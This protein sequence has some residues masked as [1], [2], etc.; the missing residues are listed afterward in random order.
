[1]GTTIYI[2]Q[3][4]IIYYNNLRHGIPKSTYYSDIYIETFL[5]CCIIDY[6]KD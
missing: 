3:I 5:N 2:K 6:I 1:M 4:R